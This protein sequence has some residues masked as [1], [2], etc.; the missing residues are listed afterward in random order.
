MFALSFNLQFFF[1]YLTT[2]YNPSDV[3]TI[4]YTKV[5]HQQQ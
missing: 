4:V 1:V 5:V 2:F 3:Y